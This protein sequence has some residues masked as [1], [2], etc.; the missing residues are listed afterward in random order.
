V[1][2]AATPTLTVGPLTPT[3]SILCIGDSDT[4]GFGDTVTMYTVGLGWPNYLVDGLN[5]NKTLNWA[6]QRMNQGS[7]SVSNLAVLRLPAWMP[8]VTKAPEFVNILVGNNDV[9][10][11]S[12]NG[13]NNFT[14]NLA[15]LLDYTHTNFPRA[16]VYASIMYASNTVYASRI[17]SMRLCLTNLVSTRSSWAYTGPDW[18]QILENGNAGATYMTDNLHPNHAGYL[19]MATKIREMLG[20]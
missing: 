8:Y 14:N 17:T 19:L 12:T 5:T 16:K 20:L 15:F 13:A 2:Y 7:Q 1:V 18:S 9:T 10:Y 3:R 11:G 6:I 4:D